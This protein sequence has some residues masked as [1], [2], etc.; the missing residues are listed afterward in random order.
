MLET[1]HIKDALRRLYEGEVWHGP[2]IKEILIDITPEQA[3]K[4]LTPKSKNIAEYLIH[5]TNWRTFALEKLTGSDTFDIILNSEADWSVVNE[6]TKD[7]WEEIQEGYE[8]SQ[9]EILE[10][11]ETYTDRKLENIVSGRKYSFYTLLYGVIHHDIYHSG[12]MMMLKRLAL[13]M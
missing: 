4:R 8:E 12:Q 13:E 1:K 6:I 3:V 7:K 10:V 5:I 11:L 2:S 9:K